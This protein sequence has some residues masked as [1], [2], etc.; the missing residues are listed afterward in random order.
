MEALVK[1]DKETGL[2]IRSSYQGASGLMAMEGFREFG[3]VTIHEAV[4]KGSGSIFLTGIR[5]FDQNGVLLIDLS[6][7]RL[8]SYS[9][10]KV[11]KAVL[12]ELIHLL[13]ESASRQGL[14]L[15][16]A[17]TWEKLNNELNIVFYADSYKAILPLAKEWGIDLIK[18]E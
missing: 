11:R 18:S 1:Q 4:L 10:E 8:T 7:D 9:R 16:A 5:V 2:A 6:F 15:D 13:T 12:C 3:T 14:S 17:Y